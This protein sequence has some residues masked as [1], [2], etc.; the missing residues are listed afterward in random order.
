MCILGMCV[1]MFVVCIVCLYSVSVPYVHVAVLCVHVSVPYVHVSVLCVHVSVL[2]VHVS[3]LMVSPPTGSTTL[4]DP[5][6]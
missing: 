5:L 1:H 4:V 6:Y 3:V 2:C